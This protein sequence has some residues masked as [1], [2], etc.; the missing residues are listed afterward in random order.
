[1]FLGLR[2][3]DGVTEEEFFRSFAL[4]MKEIYGEILERLIKENLL[5]VSG[6]RY[7]LTGRGTDISNKVLS[8]FLL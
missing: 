6:T 5:A 8:E 2:T 3:T 7:Y 1:M 4:D